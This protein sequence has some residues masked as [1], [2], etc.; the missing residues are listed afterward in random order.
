[1]KL[2]SVYLKMRVLG[3][4][5]TVAGKTRDERMLSRLMRQPESRSACSD[6]PNSVA[7]SSPSE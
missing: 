7:H 1:M 2:P 5:D 6:K 4:I 3:A